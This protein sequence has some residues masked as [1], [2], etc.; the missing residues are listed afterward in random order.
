FTVSLLVTELAFTDAATTDRAKAAVLIASLLSAVVACVLLKRRDAKYRALW[1]EETRDE[2]RDTVPD[3]D[4]PED[5]VR[6]PT[7]AARRAAERER[8]REREAAETHPDD[9]RS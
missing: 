8:E 9:G 7:E 2:D 3:I 6:R 1:E 4:Q 5:P